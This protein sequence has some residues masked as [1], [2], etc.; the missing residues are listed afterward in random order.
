M[1]LDRRIIALESKANAGVDDEPIDW[2]PG[3]EHLPPMTNREFR[4][5]LKWMH[6]SGAGRLPLCPHSAFTRGSTN[7]AGGGVAP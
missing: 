3:L 2:G 4:T 6:E 7:T 5:M 1:T